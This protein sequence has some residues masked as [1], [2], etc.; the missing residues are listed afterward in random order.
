MILLLRQGFNRVIDGHI[1]GEL[2][3]INEQFRSSTH[4]GSG[5]GQP[6]LTAAG[7][8]K[9]FRFNADFSITQE[10]QKM[11]FSNSGHL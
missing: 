5:G 11:I 8:R 9:R 2:T 7:F 1:C 4:R 10:L 6:H 3:A